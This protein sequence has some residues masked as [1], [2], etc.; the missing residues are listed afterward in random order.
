LIYRIQGYQL[1]AEEAARILRPVLS[2]LRNKLSIIPG[3]EDW[4]KTTRGAGYMIDAG[5]GDNE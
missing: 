2:R 1:E 4:I 5:L 3:G